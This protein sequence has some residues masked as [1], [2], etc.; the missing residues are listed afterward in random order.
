MNCKD[1]VLKEK[2][3][4]NTIHSYTPQIY[5]LD[6][7]VLDTISI[8]QNKFV[9]PKLKRGIQNTFINFGLVHKTHSNSDTSVVHHQFEYPIFDLH[10]LVSSLDTILLDDN[11]DNYTNIHSI[12]HSNYIIPDESDVII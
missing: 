11:D 4:N 7:T 10:E 3:I 8:V 9:E 6:Q 12:D 5:S 2:Y 1:E